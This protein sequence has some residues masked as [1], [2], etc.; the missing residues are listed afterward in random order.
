MSPSPRRIQI[1]GSSNAGKSTLAARLASESGYP[2][3]ELDA[4]NF[5]PNWRGRN[6]HDPEEFRR[7][8]R[9]AT[10]GDAWIVAGNYSVYCREL[11]WPRA[12]TIIWLDFPLPL[13]SLR[14][15]RRSWR[16]SRKKELLWG[17]N[18]EQFWPQLRFW[19]PDSLLNWL[20]ANHARQ[21]QNLLNAKVD[22]RW[23]HLNFIHL[24]SPQEAS[25]FTFKT[26]N[27]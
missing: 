22:P 26:K 7:L 2:Y 6:Q 3:V 17:T 21:N 15:I 5:E 25:Q 11:T 8:I 27:P 24:T 16:R 12:D 19:H 9:E 23:A 10:D 13:L 1:V 4:L 20:W 14:L 18:Y